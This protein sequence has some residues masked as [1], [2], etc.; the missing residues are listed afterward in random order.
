MAK[1]F[2]AEIKG[3][4]EFYAK[5]RSMASQMSSVLE[6]AAQAGADVF[7]DEANHN[8]PGPHIDTELVKKTR[9]F[10][11]MDIGPD[12][13]HW[14]YRFFE[15]G[16]GP[17]EITPDETGGLQFPGAIGEMIVRVVVSHQGMGAKPFLRPAFD[18]KKGQADEATGQKFLDVINKH[19][20]RS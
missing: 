1:G 4:E 7:K 8:A 9:G 13:E 2:R 11:E 18:D 17:H 20:E 10:A 15:T 19:V 12:D 3:D 6:E 14:Y 16:A 5:L